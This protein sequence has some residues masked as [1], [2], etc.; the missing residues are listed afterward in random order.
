MFENLEINNISPVVPPV[1]YHQLSFID[2]F[3]DIHRQMS[4]Y[5]ELHDLLLTKGNIEIYL[6]QNYPNL[7]TDKRSLYLQ[8]IK[9]LNHEIF[10]EV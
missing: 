5:F 6:D 9:P 7:K 4:E 1:G 3:N 10:L 8:L 2:A